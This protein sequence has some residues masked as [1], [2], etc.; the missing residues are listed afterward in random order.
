MEIKSKNKFGTAIILAG[1]KSS[2]MGFDKQK[3]Q[4]G[5]ISMVCYIAK[6]LEQIFDDIIIVTNTPEY[7]TDV[8]KSNNYRFVVDIFKEKGPLG[9]LHAGLQNAT[10]QWSFVTACDM[11]IINIDYIKMMKKLIINEELD[12]D[13]IFSCV[14]EINGF[15]E[16]F[17][18]F[19]ATDK[20]E[21]VEKGI[22]EERLKLS[23]FV[24]EEKSRI[25][26]EEIA[27]KF[28]NKLSMFMNLNTLMQLK[29]NRLLD[30]TINL[31]A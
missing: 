27:I 2:R 18:A 14:T 5:G 17:N 28:N 22:N 4:I 12:R 25:I 15:I 30:G 16:P 19:Y 8:A 24:I 31:P 6:Q 1:G 13:N 11:P 21:Q 20:K 26:T 10:S 29:M 3:I 9:G 7:Y 23:R